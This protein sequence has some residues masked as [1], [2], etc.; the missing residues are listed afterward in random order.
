LQSHVQKTPVGRLGRFDDVV[1]AV[2]FLAFNT[3]A[4]GAIVKLDG[5]LRL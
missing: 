3:F 4:N 1:N 2:E 5:G